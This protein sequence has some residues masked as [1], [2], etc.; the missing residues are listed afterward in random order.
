MFKSFFM[1]GF[2]C[3]TGFNRQGQW[4]D[5]IAA[6]HH[7][8]F[9]DEDY[10]RIKAL[11]IQAARES[12]R[13]PLVNRKMGYDFCSVA[14]F[15][16]ASR[17][18][19]IDVVWD[20]F[21]FGYPP[22]LD[23]FSDEFPDRFADYCYA[24]ALYL[25]RH[26]DGRTLHFTPINE[27]SFFSWAAGD[28]GLFAPHCNNRGFDLKVALIRAA[29]QGINAIKAVSPDARIINVDS[30]CRVVAPFDAPPEML[31]DAEN[32]NNNAV[33]ESWDMLAGRL[34][35]ELGGSR[36][37]LD[38]IGVNYY[39]TNQWQIDQVGA[40]LALDDPRCWSLGQLLRWAHERT[41]ADVIVSET[42]HVGDMRPLWMRWMAEDVEALLLNSFPVHG[43]CLYPILGMPEWH[44]P[45]V[46]TR[47]GLW[48]LVPDLNTGELRRELHEPTHV[49]FRQARRLERL[50]QDRIEAPKVVAQGMFRG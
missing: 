3:A 6:T 11:G 45:E 39:W 49:A 36:D 4:I 18:Q 10:A 28:A 14:P 34:L 50:H 43:V 8:R 15:V 46:W 31:H 33:F 32:F 44:E 41:G 38:I 48:D 47:M 1:A 26:S 24:T 5:Q 25:S 42:G 7:D 13:W 40:P 22:G 19:E 17:R 29:I 37:H 35:P 30:L 16:E 12:V 2:E 23:L 9:A 27:P 21:H 20:L